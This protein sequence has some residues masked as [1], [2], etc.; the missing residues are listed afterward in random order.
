M[1][2]K[3]SPKKSLFYN[4]MIAIVLMLLFQAFIMPL[5]SQVRV[6]EVRYSDFLA[7]LEEGTVRGSPRWIRRAT[8][9]SLPPRTRRETSCIFARGC[10]RTRN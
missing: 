10:G 7:M 1:E 3:R 9:S 6:N 2:E 4:I 5:F 8:P